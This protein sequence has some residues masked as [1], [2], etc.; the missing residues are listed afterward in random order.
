MKS[1]LP[2]LG[3]YE[4]QQNLGRGNVAEV[5]KAFDISAGRYVAIKILHPDLLNDPNFILRFEHEAQLLTQL[6]HPNI[7]RLRDFQRSHYPGSN[8]N[9]AYIVMDYIEGQTLANY[10]LNTSGMKKFPSP[11]HIVQ[12]L[13]SIA[14]AIDYAHHKGSIHYNI[15]PANI[16]LDKHQNTSN[17]A[18]EP[19]ITDFGT[20]KIL[21]LPFDFRKGLETE[22]ALYISPEQALGYTGNELS[23]IYSLGIILYEICTGAPP[24][25]GKSS[26]EITSQQINAAP[27][28]P[29]LNNPAIPP[30]LS[31][32]MLRSLAKD[33]SARYKSATSMVAA[34]AEAFDIL[35]PENL[36]LTSDHADSM[37]EP[38]IYKPLQTNPPLGTT[39]NP[40]GSFSAGEQAYQRKV[41]GLSTSPVNVSNIQPEAIVSNPLSTP[42]TPAIIPP[43]PYL[44]NR[45]SNQS[46]ITSL[47]THPLQPS[48]PNFS[49]PTTSNKNRKW[50]IITLI[51][52]LIIVLIS[53]IPGIYYLS[54]K[55]NSVVVPPV[56]GHA[57]FTSSGVLNNNTG[58]LNNNTV[59]KPMDELLI[60]L[61][62]LHAPAPGKNYYAWLLG[63]KKNSQS[64]SLLLTTFML[65]GSNAHFL[66]KA[67]QH[68]DLLANFSRF[69]I[70]EED[71][72]TMPAQPSTDASTWRY[73]AE[74]TQS[75]APANVD[76]AR[77]SFLDHLR[78]LLVGDPQLQTLGLTGGLESWQLRNIG[79]ILE[80]STSARDYWKSQKGPALQLMR[81]H[82]IRILDYL[83][84]AGYVQIDVPA[85]TSPLV[86]AR[87]ALLELDQQT[88]SPPGL[89]ASI[90]S[91][92]KNMINDPGVSTSTRNL[93]G[94]INT[95]MS[96]VTGWLQQVRR[97]ARQLIHLTDD[98][99]ILPSTLD[100]LDAMATQALYAYIGRLAPDTNQIQGGAVQIDYGLQHLSNFNI[101]PYISQ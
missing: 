5:W 25:Q 82:F 70:T 40:V 48:S 14:N 87:V 30:A 32:V 4:L 2:R 35:V 37:N 3:N 68:Q 44:D 62:N 84:S 101:R 89:T 79:K 97:Y 7:V 1:D 26:S 100:L 29:A 73:Y 27:P 52:A 49:S 64:S 13:T 58:V 50:L 81:N 28:S 71:A 90:S 45:N 56:V 88:Q 15:T 77:L 69:L 21:G 12:L 63:D 75:P 76:S 22:T 86:D 61:H 92:L 24:F 39:P 10:I 18:G 23:D 46:K 51:A 66:Y 11:T 34:V 72:S 59:I 65:N 6:R 78:Y 53:V 43:A 47:P 85:N 36:M 94:Q 93:L 98:S 8:Y 16:L 17:P 33:P 80:W 60:D 54:H 31:M 42:I 96:D 19:M 55:Q 38:T 95:E 20:A 83:D 57:F 74:L 91:H 9:A 41:S 67:P 99:L